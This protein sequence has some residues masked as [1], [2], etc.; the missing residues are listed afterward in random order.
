MQ[1]GD[2]HHLYFVNSELILLFDRYLHMAR[3]DNIEGLSNLIHLD[4]FLIFLK[5]LDSH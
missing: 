1:I 5:V 3:M 2:G 4:D